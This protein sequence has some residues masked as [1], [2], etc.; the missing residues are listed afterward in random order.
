MMHVP[1][2][3]DIRPVSRQI[4][5]EPQDLSWPSNRELKLPWCD[6]CQRLVPVTEI[7]TLGGPKP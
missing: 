4:V 5:T 2:G 3:G 7:T 1:C 6:R